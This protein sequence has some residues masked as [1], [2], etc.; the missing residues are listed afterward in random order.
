MIKIFMTNR[1]AMERVLK[2][3]DL[4]AQVAEDEGVQSDVDGMNNYEAI[5][6][7]QDFMNDLMR[8]D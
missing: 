4:G 8:E 5:H 2:L 3:A 6:Q 1:E 7:M